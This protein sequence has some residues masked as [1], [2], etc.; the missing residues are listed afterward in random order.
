MR[1]SPIGE[2]YLNSSKRVHFQGKHSGMKWGAAIFGGAAT[3]GVIGGT[4]LMSGGLAVIPWALA[5][6]GIGAG[7][8]ALIGNEI[9]KGNRN[10]K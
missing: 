9:D 4:I 2:N 6:I 7:T 1:I 10:N 5:Y 3:A 8:G